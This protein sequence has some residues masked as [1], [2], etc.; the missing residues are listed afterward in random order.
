MVYVFF[1]FFSRKMVGQGPPR[2]TNKSFSS[3]VKGP[4]PTKLRRSLLGHSPH[5]ILAVTVILSAL[6]GEVYVSCN[7][8]LSC[9]FAFKV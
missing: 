8:V 4:T 3:I 5:T 6:T 9:L 7:F 1:F 2:S